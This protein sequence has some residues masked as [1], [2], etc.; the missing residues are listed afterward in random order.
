VSHRART[1]FLVGGLVVALFVTG[2]VIGWSRATASD[3][4]KDVDI[5]VD[6]LAKINQFYVDPVDPSELVE[7]AVNGMLRDL[8]PFSAYLDEDSFE[9]LQITTQGQFGGLGI[10]VSVRDNYPTVISPLEGTPAYSLGI[11]SGDVIVDIEGESTRDLPIDKVVNKLRGPE[12]TQVTIKIRREGQAED[13]DY[14]I[15]REIIHVKS[16]P[17]AMV[18]DGNVGYVRVSNFSATTGEEL[19]E[20]L[21]VLE[22]N[23]A[24]ALILDLRENPGGLLSEAVDVAE[25]FLDRGS[26]VVETRGRARNTDHTYT[27]SYSRPHLS[28]PLV[29]LVSRG[30]ASASEIVAGAIQD[31][32]RGLVVGQ[33]TFGKGSV[34]SVI[35][36]PGSRA[37]LKLT[38]AKYYT[39]AGR[40][41][42]RDHPRSR[43]E[44]IAM[45][46]AE[47]AEAE[48][49]STDKH[50]YFTDSGREVFGGGGIS[51]DVSVELDTLQTLSREALRRGLYFK[52]AVKY[53]AKN[54]DQGEVMEV[55]ATVWQD[56][57]EFLRSEEFEFTAAEME[58][59]REFLELGIKREIARRVG[60]D[61]AAF[62]AVTPGDRT[63]QKALELLRKANGPQ[64]LI[65]LS[66]IQ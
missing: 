56:F 46:E 26:V 64:E 37:A 41:I 35:D 30:S 6:V 59:Q 47:E 32:D 42:H 3:R 40:S 14:T 15:V 60:G 54:P 22:A 16:V 23:G 62:R 44:A 33:V 20:A 49:D 50:V 25:L 52:Y 17:Y 43:E 18:L 1:R 39:P 21:G 9:D 11:Q 10:V 66:S 27:A 2:W 7:G 51:P 45:A 57:A 34:Q 36:L 13:R 65:Q 24:R 61:A 55:D 29:V 5:F 28:Q 12:G 48:T 38:T 31:H 58:E 63:L 53:V 4:Y 19:R 8:D